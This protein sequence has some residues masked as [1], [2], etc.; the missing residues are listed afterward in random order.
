M[1]S[2]YIVFLFP[3]LTT[4]DESRVSHLDKWRYFDKIN[5]SRVRKLRFIKGEGKHKLASSFSFFF[6]MFKNKFHFISCLSSTPYIP[7]PCA[8]A[9]ETIN[10][11]FNYKLFSLFTVRINSVAIAAKATQLKKHSAP[12]ELPAG[13]PE[14]VVENYLHWPMRKLQHWGSQTKSV[15]SSLSC[16]SS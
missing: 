14:E 10:C 12:R 7:L 13:Q 9:R 8:L 6:L 1:F 11:N 15:T 5:S 3:E 16:S 2:V 4:S